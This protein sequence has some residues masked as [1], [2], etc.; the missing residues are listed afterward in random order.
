MICI[1][2]FGNIN[3]TLVMK[4]YEI[5][6]AMIAVNEYSMSTYKIQTIITQFR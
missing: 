3:T 5:K 4:L 1:I 6:K 2:V